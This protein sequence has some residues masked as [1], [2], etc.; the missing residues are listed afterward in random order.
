MN[1]SALPDQP[2]DAPA[3]ELAKYEG[4][5]DP[6]AAIIPE[7]IELEVTDKHTDAYAWVA[8]TA[9]G[10]YYSEIAKDSR[11]R[12]WGTLD[13][14]AVLF[15]D[16]LPIAVRCDIHARGQADPGCVKC[17][18]A[19]QRRALRPHR[20]QVPIGGSAYFER[21]RDREL[22]S[23]RIAHTWTIVGWQQSFLSVRPIGLKISDAGPRNM[24]VEFYMFVDDLG[25]TYHTSNLQAI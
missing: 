10:N 19:D 2:D 16:L 9:D 15:V 18:V 4:I 12:Q 6:F 11:H 14:T 7:G 22:I 24:R 13:M 20:L 3:P 5:I 21:R 1:M 23:N 25:R 17:V 8:Y